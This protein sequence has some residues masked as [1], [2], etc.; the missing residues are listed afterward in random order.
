MCF[1]R[2]PAVTAILSSS[3]FFFFPSFTR[4]SRCHSPR[5]LPAPPPSQSHR[6]AL[7]NVKEQNICFSCD[8]QSS[9]TLH[10]FVW[11]IISDSLSLCPSP[12]FPTFSLPLVPLV[13]CAISSVSF[14]FFF[15]SCFKKILSFCI[16]FIEA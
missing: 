2:V 10:G 6:S 3:C 12:S 7:L 5:P 4:M 1:V 14:F 11:A 9:L 8:S 13:L 15:S 16:Y